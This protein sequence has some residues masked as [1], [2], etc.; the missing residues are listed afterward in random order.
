[1]DIILNS[2]G[3]GLVVILALILAGASSAVSYN[4]G[5]GKAWRQSQQTT[6]NQQ[7]TTETENDTEIASAYDNASA[8]KS[9][10]ADEVNDNPVQSPTGDNG[11][12]TQPITYTL[13]GTI[14]STTKSSFVLQMQSAS[15]NGAPTTLRAGNFTINYTPQTKIAERTTT[16]VIPSAGGAPKI[17]TV[18]KKITASTLQSGQTVTVTTNAEVTGQEIAASEIVVA[19]V[20]R[21]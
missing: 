17:T 18:T 10:P 4:L 2:R 6:N 11:A 1:M 20:V 16:V 9:S 14:T 15:K 13:S 3:I 7:P 12:I 21:K 8:D 5:Y 19:K